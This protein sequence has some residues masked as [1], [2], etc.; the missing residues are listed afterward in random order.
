MVTYGSNVFSQTLRQWADAIPVAE[1]QHLAYPYGQRRGH[2]REEP[3]EYPFTR[4][5]SVGGYRDNPWIMGLYSGYGTVQQTRERFRKLL[6]EGQTGLSIALDL[7]T[8]MGI[9]SDDPR[10]SGEVG[11]VGVAIDTVDDLIDLWDGLP[12]ENL[13]QARTT[14]NSIGPMFVALTLAAL[15]ELGVSPAG[16]RLMLQNDPLKEYCARGTYIFRPQ[17]SLTLA[18]DVMEYTAGHLPHWDPIEFCGYHIRDAGATRV[19][20]VAIATAHGI[21]YLDEA[22]RRGVNIESVAH[23]LFLFLSAGVEIFEEAAKIRAARRLWARILHERYGVSRDHSAVNVFSY[24]LGG[25]L[26]AQGPM[27]NIVRITCEALAAVLG[28]IQTLA[29]SSYD[30]ALGLPAPEAAT[31]ALRTQQILALE[32]GV[33]REPDPLGGS[34]HVERLTDQLEADILRTVADILD[35]GG[36]ISELESG[37]TRR[38]ISESAY[39]AQLAVERGERTVVGVNCFAEEVSRI[40]SVLRVSPELEQNQITRL[41]ASRA[42]RNEA[43]VAECVGTIETAAARGQNVIPALIDAAKARVT[44]G[45]MCQAVA[46]VHGR[47]D[48]RAVDLT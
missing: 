32:S 30:E 3:G 5:S 10:A 22:T 25:A 29:T 4:G 38:L 2:G 40:T 21:A 43:R 37:S 15:E 34:Y 23:S 11:K 8:Q 14:A 28:G 1:V 6:S 46:D 36:A 42:R 39:R 13:R 24:T 18:V 44:I 35:R 12:L 45:E 7:P 27:N 19:Q 41:A 47:Y 9:D 48:A 33:A 17:T 16:F 26:T 20:E 31:L